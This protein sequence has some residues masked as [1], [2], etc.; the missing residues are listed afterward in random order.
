MPL[1]TTIE[2]LTA[3]AEATERHA[4]TMTYGGYSICTD[5][6]QGICTDCHV[7]M[8]SCEQCHGVGFHIVNCPEMGYAGMNIASKETDNAAS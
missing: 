5:D 3:D 4:L 6:G 2:W 8:E 1:R 7:A